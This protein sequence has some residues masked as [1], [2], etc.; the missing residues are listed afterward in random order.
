M[1]NYFRADLKG[2]IYCL[3]D[4]VQLK[5]VRYGQD[6]SRSNITTYMSFT[7]IRWSECSCAVNYHH[8]KRRAGPHLICQC[9]QKIAVPSLILTEDNF[10]LDNCGGAQ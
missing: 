2:Y 10:K 3:E 6:A 8:A 1:R 4:D 5:I 7:V 9:D